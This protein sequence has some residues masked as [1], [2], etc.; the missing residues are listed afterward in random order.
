MRRTGLRSPSASC[1]WGQADDRVRA[2]ANPAG[3]QDQV[4]EGVD[5]A[6][7]LVY[8]PAITVTDGSG[9]DTGMELTFGEQDGRTRRTIAQGGSPAA[10]VRGD[11]AGGWVSILDGLRHAVAAA[12]TDRW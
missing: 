9:I 11:F 10:G 2:S 8:R 3:S 1:W 6:R 7:R 4:F 5:W 12:I